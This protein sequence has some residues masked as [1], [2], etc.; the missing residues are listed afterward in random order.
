MSQIPYILA[1]ID[2]WILWRQSTEEP[3][4]GVYHVL[5]H[6]HIAYEQQ[7]G[8]YSVIIPYKVMNR[9]FTTK[10]HIYGI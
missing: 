1:A 5:V 4:F 3:N 7:A 8:S 9:L 2:D 10:Y 6:A